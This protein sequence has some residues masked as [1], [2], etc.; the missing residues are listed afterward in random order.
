MIRVVVRNGRL[1]PLDP[2]PGDWDEGTE[3]S[4]EMAISS[5]TPASVDQWQ[6]QIDEMEAHAAQ[7]SP[8][9][10]DELTAILE[11]NDRQQKELVR[12]QWN[13]TP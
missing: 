3:L 5:D 6:R 4:I 9:D 10:M 12:Q 8:E 7:V 2:L 11:D 1:E 13:L